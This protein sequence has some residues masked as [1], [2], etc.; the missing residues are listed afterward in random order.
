MTEEE[1]MQEFENYPHGELVRAVYQMKTEL[2]VLYEAVNKMSEMQ[3]VHSKVLAM[4]V[5]AFEEA[6]A[7]QSPEPA[8]PRPGMYL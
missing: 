2:L 1:L 6:E 7:E 3:T 4:F 5:S 8:P